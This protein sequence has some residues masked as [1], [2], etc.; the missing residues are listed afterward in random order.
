MRVTASL[1][2]T[3]ATLL[4]FCLLAGGLAGAQEPPAATKAHAL[5]K[6][7]VGVW[8]ADVT[9]WLAGPDGPKEEGKAVESNRMLGETWLLSEFKGPFGGIPFEGFGQFGYDPAK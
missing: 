2:R 1:S 8:D 7:D 9:M 6:K 4:A 3:L 5:L